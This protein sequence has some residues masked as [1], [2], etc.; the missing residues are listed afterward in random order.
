MFTPYLDYRINKSQCYVES[1]FRE[2]AV[3]PVGAKGIC[4]FMDGTWSDVTSR[5]QLGKHDVFDTRMNIYAN[6]FYNNRLYRNWTSPRPERDRIS[7]MLASY[8]AGLGNLLRAQRLCGMPNLYEDIVICL[9]SITGSNAN[10]TLNYVPKTWDNY[11][12]LLLGLPMR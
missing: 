12:R 11:Q 1:H 7:L 3:S 5:W 2:T 10:E 8:N 4:Q 9:P 6:A